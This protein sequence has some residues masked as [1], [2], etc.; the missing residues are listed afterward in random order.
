MN[1]YQAA[2][3][4]RGFQPNGRKV[5]AGLNDVIRSAFPGGNDGAADRGKHS[6]LYFRTEWLKEKPCRTRRR[7]RVLG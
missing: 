1:D 3:E 6:F 4:A 7:E 2:R 5:M